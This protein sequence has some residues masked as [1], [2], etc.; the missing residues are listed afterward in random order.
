MV[1]HCAGNGK[2]NGRR[3][4]DSRSNIRALFLGHMTV[5]AATVADFLET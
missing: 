2:T 3:A 1:M 4:I 5:D